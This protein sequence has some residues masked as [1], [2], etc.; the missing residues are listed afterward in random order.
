M[1][2]FLCTFYMFNEITRTIV[3]TWGRINILLGLKLLWKFC[4][5]LP[6]SSIFYN[7]SS[8]NNYKVPARCLV[9][10]MFKMPWLKTGKTHYIAELKL[11]DIRCA[12][13]GLVVCWMFDRVIMIDLQVL[14]QR[15]TK[16]RPNGV[17]CALKVIQVINCNV[18]KFSMKLAYI[19][20]Y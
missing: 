3:C 4:K 7:G 8:K 6:L 17:F 10:A 5:Y 12:I 1:F 18:S 15:Y 14:I 2:N 16:I 19:S 20:L 13:N 11:L 9:G